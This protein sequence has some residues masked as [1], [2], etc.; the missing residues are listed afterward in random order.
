MK[1]DFRS[2]AAQRG[3]TVDELLLHVLG[4]PS[5]RLRSMTL[6]VHFGGLT[7][8]RFRI[9]YQGPSRARIKRPAPDDAKSK[10]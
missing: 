5:K 3:L 7:A 10:E 6:D 4:A 8:H 9:T 2:G 1:V